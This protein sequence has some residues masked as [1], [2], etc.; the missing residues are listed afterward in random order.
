MTRP[1]G[2]AHHAV[3]DPRPVPTPSVW[4]LLLATV[5]PVL[6]VL[7]VRVAIPVSRRSDELTISEE[8]S[9]DVLRIIVQP[10]AI[11][12]IVLGIIG[13]L[14]VRRDPHLYRWQWVGF[15]AIALGC[16]EILIYTGGWLGW[17]PS[18]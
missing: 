14:I 12:A 2:R 17:W 10:V 15:T 4:A 7:W 16:M 18:V 11:A 1:R 3:T 6:Y 13:V 5:V 8:R 9:L